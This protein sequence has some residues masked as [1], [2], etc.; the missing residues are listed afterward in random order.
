MGS[1]VP[2]ANVDLA[3][4][5][6]SVAGAR[7]GGWGQTPQV[8]GQDAFISV[9]MQLRLPRARAVVQLGS[10]NPPLQ[11]YV[12]AGVGV[13]VGAEVGSEDTGCPVGATDGAVEE[14]AAVGAREGAEVGSELAGE[15]VGAGEGSVVV[16]DRVGIKVGA[17]VVG[18][19]VGGSS[20]TPQVT[21]QIRI[22]SFNV[23]SRLPLFSNIEHILAS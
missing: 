7:V 1:V 10:S 23:Q 4:V 2:G 13:S 22:S 14:G 20:Q 17:V 3:L 16:G 5:G 9:D 11:L 19:N 12:G 6:V 21:G 15:P 8:T 18:L